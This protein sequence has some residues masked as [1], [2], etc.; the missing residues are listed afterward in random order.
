MNIVMLIG[1][2]TADPKVSNSSTAVAKYNLAVERIG[3]K[4]GQQNADFIPCTAFGKNAEF[5]Q[6][7]LSKGM[8]IAVQGRIQ[9]GSFKKE[10]GTR[11]YTTEVIV[12]R[13][14]FCEKRSSSYDGYSESSED[15]AEVADDEELPF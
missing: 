13:H 1:R 10:D 4:E 3:S 2:L 5:A 15:Y 14:E 7:Y 8:K 12:D 9:T 6:K 11:V